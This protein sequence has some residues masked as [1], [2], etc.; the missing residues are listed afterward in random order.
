MRFY[1]ILGLL[2][3]SCCLYSCK[4][5]NTEK[6]YYPDGKVKKIVQLSNGK[7]NGLYKSYYENGQLAEI[8]PYSNSTKSGE[9]LVYDTLGKLKLRAFFVNDSLNGVYL[10]YYPNSHI[11]RDYMYYAD[12]M[13]GERLEYYPNGQLNSMCSYKNNKKNGEMWFFSSR[14][15][16]FQYDIYKD[17]SLVYYKQYDSSSG[18]PT[19][20]FRDIYIE[21]KDTFKE[22]ERL[23][24]KLKFFGPLD[25]NNRISTDAPPYVGIMSHV[26]NYNN[27]ISIVKDS[28][29]YISAP[30]KPGLHLLIVN[31][32]MVIDTMHNEVFGKKRIIVLPD[33]SSKSG[34]FQIHKSYI[35]VNT[36]YYLK[37][38]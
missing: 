37:W 34:T 27:L 33:D 18:M 17:D 12:K 25:S 8:G 30:L 31:I 3:F 28:G 23:E 35:G 9:H 19:Y 15:K 10:E 13:N 1:K 11:A 14:G 22:G 24:A 4:N 32:P 16:L 7:W 36:G 2:L 21:C 20:E 6:E 5:I 38:E 29:H 26:E